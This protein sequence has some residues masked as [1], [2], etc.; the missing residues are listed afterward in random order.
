MTPTNINWLHWS[1]VSG[2]VWWMWSKC[3]TKNT[4]KK[5]K[6]QSDTH[7]T[8]NTCNN[9][10]SRNEARPTT[11]CRSFFLWAQNGTDPLLLL[12]KHRNTKRRC[13]RRQTLLDAILTKVLQIYLMR[14]QCCRK[15]NGWVIWITKALNLHKETN[16]ENVGV[17]T[18]WIK[19]LPCWPI[20]IKKMVFHSSSHR[21]LAHA[22]C[23]WAVYE[24]RYFLKCSDRLYYLQRV[25][26]VATLQHTTYNNKQPRT[27]TNMHIRD[28]YILH[29]HIYHILHVNTVV[30]TGT[31]LW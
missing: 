13:G 25:L 28:R 30:G 8:S 9:E 7:N 12:P 19:W 29:D 5:N 1:I 31:Q 16:N 4:K 6:K 23:R 10:R 22:V 15:R 21:R 24:W 17:E 26:R 18:S 14:R 11:C 3:K 2:M 20:T 27:A